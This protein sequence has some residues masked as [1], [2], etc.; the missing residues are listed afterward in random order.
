MRVGLGWVGLGWVGLNT[1]EVIPKRNG[2]ARVNLNYF[3]RWSQIFARIITTAPA[4]KK[5]GSDC[6]AP[7]LARIERNLFI[8]VR[9][10][11]NFHADK[12]RFITRVTAVWQAAPTFSR[13]DKYT[14][15]GEI[16]ADG[17]GVLNPSWP[18]FSLVR[19]GPDVSRVNT[20]SDKFA[21][22][23]R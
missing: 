11:C 13:A 9:P 12:F 16:C 21:A 14:F 10:N 8:L 23:N 6:M 22:C 7:P 18:V 15:T 4:K 19:T 20:C 2:I 17:S 3:R 5:T 1:G